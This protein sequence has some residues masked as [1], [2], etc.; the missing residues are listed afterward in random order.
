MTPA[1]KVLRFVC[2]LLCLATFALPIVTMI[3]HASAVQ[4][5]EREW[6]RECQRM[7][8]MARGARR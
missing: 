6:E 7:E 3:V 1:A 4:Q 5:A 8:R 2:G